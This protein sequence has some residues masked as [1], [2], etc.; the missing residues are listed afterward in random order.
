MKLTEEIIR[1]RIEHIKKVTHDNEQAHWNEDSL[2]YDFIECIAEGC[3]SPEEAQCLAAI[4][5]TASDIDY[6]RW[7]A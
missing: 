2:Y 5:L 3:Y 4:V 6:V 7:Y 1:E